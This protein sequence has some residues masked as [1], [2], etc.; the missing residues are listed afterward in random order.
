[1]TTTGVVTVKFSRDFYAM[2]KKQISEVAADGTKKVKEKSWFSRGTKLIVA[3]YRR[4]D[5]FVCKKYK[6][7]FGHQ[8]YRITEV[9]GK[10]LKLTSTR[11]GMVGK[12]DE[13][14]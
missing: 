3:G 11:Y 13:E 12:D 8:L 10:N 2:F 6:N 1:M 14:W 4:D 9:N 5:T 7:T